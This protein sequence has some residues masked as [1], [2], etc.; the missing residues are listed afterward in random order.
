[1]RGRVKGGHVV[2]LSK[3]E[4]FPQLLV[5]IHFGQYTWVAHRKFWTTWVLLL[6]TNSE[7]H[8]IML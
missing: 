5:N 2:S 1:M 3:C 8:Y 6:L 4:N 7:G